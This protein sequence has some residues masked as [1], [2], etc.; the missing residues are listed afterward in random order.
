MGVVYIS[1]DGG[2]DLSDQVWC[3][4]KITGA[5]LSFFLGVVVEKQPSNR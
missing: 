4:P 3:I 1:V 5:F 2:G